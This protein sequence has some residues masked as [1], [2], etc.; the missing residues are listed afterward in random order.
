MLK[1]LPNAL[2]CSRL[3][4]ALPLA[5]LILQQEFFYALLL[6]AVAGITD[7][8]DGFF[9]R[10]LQALSRLGAALDPIADKI[11]I[12]LTLLCL[13]QVDA[14]PW[15]LALV[16]VVRD[17]V[18]VSGAAAYHM[19]IGP[20]EF[21]ARN[22]SK[23]NMF[24]QITYCVL[25]LSAQLTPFTPEL[26]AWSGIAVILIALVSGID[27]VVTWSRKAMSARREA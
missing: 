6:G 17:L 20:F 21:A 8:L 25:V 4:L 26:L 23:L 11:M 2:T 27:Y 3:V 24:M 9:A 7:L 14:V 15:F 22:L 16:V 1:W 19:L 13:A 5:Y 18:I 12:N 10:R